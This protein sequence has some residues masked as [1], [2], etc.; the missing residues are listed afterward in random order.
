MLLDLW[1]F[2]VSGDSPLISRL[3]LRGY[4]RISELTKKWR[5]SK[6]AGNVACHTTRALQLKS[7]I[8]GTPHFCDGE[9]L[10]T[11]AGNIFE[12]QVRTGCCQQGPI[13]RSPYFWGLHGPAL[14]LNL[15]TLGLGIETNVGLL[16]QRWICILKQDLPIRL[17]LWAQ[18]WGLKVWEWCIGNTGSG[19]PWSIWN[20]LGPATHWVLTCIGWG[21]WWAG[22][23]KQL[24]DDFLE[25]G[26]SFP[27]KW[28]S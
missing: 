15:T 20:K 12:W 23:R 7:R 22:F 9:L 2:L 4:V 16:S 18:G 24:D 21:G 14:S 11:C 17:E 10:K 8:H 27:P 19:L 1:F 3:F 6:N 5:S 13:F 25:G 28:I 26:W